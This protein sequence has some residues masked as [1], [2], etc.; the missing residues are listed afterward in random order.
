[1]IVLG[2]PL[3]AI[4]S[5]YAAT[6]NADIAINVGGILTSWNPLSHGKYWTDN[7]FTNPVADLI[8]SFL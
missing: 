1:M 2:Y 8:A 7:D 4:N 6:V 5:A 3:K